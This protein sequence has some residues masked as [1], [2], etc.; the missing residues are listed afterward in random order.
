MSITKHSGCTY[1]RCCGYPACIPSQACARV[2][3][4]QHMGANCASVFLTLLSVMSDLVASNCCVGSLYI[5]DTGRCNS[6]GLFCLEEPVVKHLLA[7]QLP[8]IH[9][10][11]VCQ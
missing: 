9:H 1:R 3:L 8:S 10:Y 4:Y 11:C 2:V 7:Y 5:I 6:L